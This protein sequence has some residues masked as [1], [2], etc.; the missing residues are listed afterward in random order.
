MSKTPQ[1]RSWAG[2]CLLHLF[3][4]GPRLQELLAPVEGKPP[5]PGVGSWGTQGILM[6]PEPFQVSLSSTLALGPWPSVLSF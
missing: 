4:V 5:L 1:P 6:W 2:S 3:I